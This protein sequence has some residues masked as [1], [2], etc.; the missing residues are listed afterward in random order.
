M[1]MH[2]SSYAVMRIG[3]II[4]NPVCRGAIILVAGLARSSKLARH[5][6]TYLIYNFL[7]THAKVATASEYR[8]ALQLIALQ[9]HLSQHANQRKTYR[10][11]VGSF[12]AAVPDRCIHLQSHTLQ[13][14]DFR[15]SDEQTLRTGA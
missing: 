6:S 5:L 13:Q 8:K 15:W 10:K 7:Q 4:K 12:C 14:A 9:L 1:M 3:C 2:A 11:C